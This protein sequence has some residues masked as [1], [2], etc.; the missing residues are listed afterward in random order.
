MAIERFKP[1][2]DKF[3]EPAVLAELAAQPVWPAGSPEGLELL[4]EAARR[5]MRGVMEELL[6]RGADINA[7]GANGANALHVALMCNAVMSSLGERQSVA[8]WL[9]ERGARVEVPTAEGASPLL[10]AC[11]QPARYNRSAARYRGDIELLLE[12]GADPNARDKHGN[13][14]ILYARDDVRLLLL[15]RGAD[16]GVINDEGLNALY[17]GAFAGGLDDPAAAEALIKAGADPR[18][19]RF[20][21]GWT[22]L[23]ANAKKEIVELLIRAGADVNA[24]TADGVS[25]LHERI[26]S[27]PA[28]TVRLLLKRGADPNAKDSHGNTPLHEAGLLTARALLEGGADPAARN[29]EGRT[30]V[31]ECLR[32]WSRSTH[33]WEKQA[34]KALEAFLGRGAD[35]NAQD[36]EGQTLLHQAVLGSKKPELTALLLE[37]GADPALADRRGWTPLHA[38]AAGAPKPSKAAEPLLEALRTRGGLDARDAS[39]KTALDLA[40]LAPA[41]ARANALRAAGALAGGQRVQAP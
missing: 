22:P 36:A 39:G 28:D 23:H 30:P 21:S 19:D 10:L 6:R 15:G 1:H 4:Q 16:A 41:P 2:L 24:K 38:W 33:S 31:L 35:P 34:L 7:L 37:K 9:L 20:K 29:A 27:G 13:A 14:P 26:K 3:D 40:V 11:R 17:G 5:G 25:V 18:A 8:E 32:R 12:R